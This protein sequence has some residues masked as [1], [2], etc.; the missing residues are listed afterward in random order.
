MTAMVNVPPRVLH[1]MNTKVVEKNPTV[2][3]TDCVWPQ[4]CQEPLSS[5]HCHLWSQLWLIPSTCHW[6]G[7]V[8]MCLWLHMWMS[9]RCHPS[10]W[11][12]HQ[13]C[14]THYNHT[15]PCHLSSKINNTCHTCGI[16][17]SST[18]SY[19]MYCTETT[20]YRES[21]KT[22][23]DTVHWS[24]PKLNCCSRSCSMA[25]CPKQFI[26]IPAYNGNIELNHL[27]QI[28]FMITWPRLHWAQLLKC[29]CIQL[30]K[31]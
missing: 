2:C 23:T 22:H 17:T 16:G 20:A 15:L 25:I 31:L 14:S 28:N 11:T 12:H 5:C 24:C 26:A 30:N 19:I 27:L 8:L 1:I 4:W 21:T 3:W 18:C 13:W 6:R 29:C 7:T 9:P 10:R